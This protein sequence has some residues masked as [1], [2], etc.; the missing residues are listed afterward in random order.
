VRLK[1]II[2]IAVTV[3]LI[4]GAYLAPSRGADAELRRSKLLVEFDNGSKRTIVVEHPSYAGLGVHQSRGGHRLSTWEY[5]M[6]KGLARC[7]KTLVYG[8]VW[9]E[10]LGV[11]YDTYNNQL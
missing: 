9:Y 4:S 5:C 3:L 10:N 11:I 6:L 7:E 2:L 1:S 8:V